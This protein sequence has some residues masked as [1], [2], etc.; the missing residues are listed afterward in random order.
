MGLI[1]PTFLGLCIS[2]MCIQGFADP[3][4]GGFDPTAEKEI[5]SGQS[6][7]KTDPI[8]DKNGYPK[9]SVINRN[10]CTFQ[11]LKFWPYVLQYRPT[12]MHIL[13]IIVIYTQSRLDF[14]S[15]GLIKSSSFN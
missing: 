15:I 6:V 1:L 12:Y 3:I 5:R 13:Y 10:T 7:P 11:K 9:I 8:R 14:Y 4:R 2:I